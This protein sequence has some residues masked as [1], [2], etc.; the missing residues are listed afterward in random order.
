MHFMQNV[1]SL[2][3]LNSASNNSSKELSGKSFFVKS[4]QKHNKLFSFPLCVLITKKKISLK[5][6]YPI[7]DRIF[8]YFVPEIELCAHKNVTFKFVSG[9]FLSSLKAKFEIGYLKKIILKI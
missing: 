8:Y 1:C 9:T 2:K 7:K 5:N 3:K 6:L 4:K